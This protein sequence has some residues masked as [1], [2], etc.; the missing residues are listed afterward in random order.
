MREEA[1]SLLPTTALS[2]LVFGA[3]G[4]L[5]FL[6]MAGRNSPA[7]VMSMIAAWVIS[8]FVALVLAHAMARR[9]PAPVR[10]ALYS[11]MLAVTVLAVGLYWNDYV[12]P[13]T[14]RAA[15]FVLVPGVSWVAMTVV[16][17]LTW[18]ISRRNR[19]LP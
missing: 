9:W 16:L 1:P 8:P 11:V 3:A 17:S 10:H 5:G 13:H 15:P 2:V 18:L 6:F 7:L 12:R 14:P 19:N 4:S